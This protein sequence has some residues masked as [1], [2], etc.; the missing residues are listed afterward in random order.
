MTVFFKHEKSEK[1]CCVPTSSGPH[2]WGVGGSVDGGAEGLKTRGVR[3]AAPPARM[4]K[5]KPGLENYVFLIFKTICYIFYS[6]KPATNRQRISNKRY[7]GEAVFGLRSRFTFTPRPS[8]NIPLASAAMP[9][10]VIYYTISNRTKKI[11]SNVSK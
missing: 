5:Q 8:G 3:G 9:S 6:K 7:F 10:H 11:E 2:L 1:T 4:A